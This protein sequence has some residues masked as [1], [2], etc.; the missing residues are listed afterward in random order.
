LLR[1][2]GV[3]NSKS[4]ADDS[5]ISGTKDEDVIWQIE[6][7]D[8]HLTDRISMKLATWAFPVRNKYHQCIQSSE[9]K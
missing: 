9:L 4:G 1:I 7:G 8:Q 6:D 2:F 3:F 5:I